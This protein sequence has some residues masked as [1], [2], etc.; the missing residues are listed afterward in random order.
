M[1]DRSVKKTWLGQSGNSLVLLLAILAIVFCIFTF[2]H[3]SYSLTNENTSEAN[4]SYYNG[5]FNWF[6]LPANWSGFLTRP[7]TIFTYMFMHDGVFHMIGNLL[8]LWM[9]GFILQDLIG[10]R[11]IIPLFIYGG[12]VG[13]LFFFACVNIFPGLKSIVASGT[14]EGA[15]AGVMAIAWAAT[16]LAPNYRFFPMILG[17]IPLWVITVIYVLIDLAGIANFS[18]AGGHISHI[19]GAL[20]GIAYMWQKRK[21]NDWTDGM[22]RFFDWVNNLFRPNVNEES[23]RKTFHYNTNGTT[24]YKKVPNLT[25]KRIDAILDKIGEQ[26]YNKL[27][28]EE[29]QILKRAAEDD[30]N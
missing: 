15:S 1:Q 28:D 4:A 8:W 19:G 23:P 17:G 5:I 16:M 26:G 11:P 14:L 6:I 2:L 30:S 3:L 13:G 18:N 29:K 22:N 10:S 7:W 20:F 9:F 12:L 27:T 25:Q 21:G 24:P